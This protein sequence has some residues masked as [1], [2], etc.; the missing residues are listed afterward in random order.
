MKAAAGVLLLALFVM[1]AAHGALHMLLEAHVT[2]ST[3][4]VR[5]VADFAMDAVL[6]GLFCLV[7]Y[8]YWRRIER[9]KHKYETLLKSSETIAK[10]GAW[11]YDVRRKRFN[12]TEG[13]WRIIE[14]DPD[15]SH[16]IE[17]CLSLV[18]AQD[19][20][21]IGRL[22]RNALH[23]GTGWQMRY[24][25]TTAGGNHKKIESR[26][27]IADIGGD[28]HLVATIFDVT[29]TAEQQRRVYFFN[30][31]VD[32]SLES[33]VLTD[34]DR[35]IFYANRAFCKMTG[36][37]TSEVLGKTPNALKS[38]GHH[39][40]AFYKRLWESIAQK[41]HWEGEL[42]NRKKSG[43]IYAERI[44]VS[45]VYHE[46]ELIGYGA[47]SSE[48]A[49]RD[50]SLEHYLHI[51]EYDPLTGLLGRLAFMERLQE[52]IDR[53]EQECIALILFDIDDF[54]RVN[55][56]LG[57]L[58]G[59]SILQ[60][61]ADILQEL[62]DDAVL[63]GHIGG[64]EFGV[65]YD[66]VACDAIM[67]KVRN[68]EVL[69][70]SPFEVDGINVYLDGSF[71]IALYP[72]HA[73]SA[74]ALLRMADVGLQKV[75]RSGKRGVQLASSG[76]IQNAGETIQLEHRMHEAL[77]KKA[78]YLHYQPKVSLA[79]GTIIGFE[80]LARWRTDAGELIPPGT[81]IPVAE[82]SDLIVKIS[83]LLY[84][85]AF[86]WADKVASNHPQ[87]SFVVALNLSARQLQQPQ[88]LLGFLQHLIEQYPNSVGHIELE[89]IE[90]MLLNNDNEVLQFMKQCKEIGISFA[91]DDFGTGYSSLSY[92][93]KF[94]VHKLKI[95]RSFVSGIL[96]DD[97]D[98]QIVNAIIQMATALG[99][100]TIA[101]GTEV[102]AE[103]A[104]LQRHGCDS[105]QG[106]YFSK[107]V[108]AESAEAMLVQQPF[109]T[110]KL[111]SKDFS[112]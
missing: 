101:E 31:L 107:P 21:R 7:G 78:F 44:V 45:A 30:A 75:K 87:S 103:V 79:D 81:F 92:L 38:S 8:H 48:I 57:L 54:K 84:A 99:F 32:H 66:E 23:E 71:G 3:L 63:I 80:A 98:R 76:T 46:K 5:G 42:L 55:D 102:P 59:D 26:G 86:A 6:I 70:A 106:Y 49:A 43:E 111:F 19:R 9:K 62:C 18:D 35:R 11:S 112:I 65:V 72:E 104:Y 88:K 74:E 37:T 82:K 68:L 17:D 94:P 16:T 24:G 13:L 58:C 2:N 25:I 29:D 20:E 51:G 108:A 77:S 53:A 100:D 52:R 1:L 27:R 95:D 69:F 22:I 10:T 91:I 39:D 14:K 4:F 56:G 12:A 109:T 85:Q 67:T 41:Q 110:D 105:A 40:A 83:E 33:V 34:P 90:R 15:H 47:V 60:Q 73:S 93:K 36:Y 28:P 61:I 97:T 50:A 96:Q 64:D 89:L